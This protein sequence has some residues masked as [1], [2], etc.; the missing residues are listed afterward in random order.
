MIESDELSHAECER[1][2]AL[3]GYDH[4]R[5]ANEML[6]RLQRPPFTNQLNHSEQLLRLMIEAET[7]A[8]NPHQTVDEYQSAIA[9]QPNDRILHYN[10]GLF[11]YDF[12]REAGAAELRTVAAMGRLPGIHSR[13][14]ADSI[15]AVGSI[16]GYGSAGDG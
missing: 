6:E 13:R 2:L 3:T 15:S 9:K 14:N 16:P 8:E 12:D 7:P 1:I 11:L 4:S 5:I 10:Y